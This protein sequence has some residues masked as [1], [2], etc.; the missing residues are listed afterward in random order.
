MYK[1][2]VGTVKG[3][4]VLSSDDR[5]NRR[6]S[7]QVFRGWKLAAVAQSVSKRFL[8]EVSSH[9]D[10]TTVHLSGDLVEWEQVDKGLSSSTATGHTL[11]QIWRF[12]VSPGILYAGALRGALPVD[13]EDRCGVYAGTTSRTVRISAGG[14]DS[15]QTLPHILQRI[16]CIQIFTDP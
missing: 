6:Q 8:A 2:I 11:D 9:V 5:K 15:W 14:G 12:G 16:L 4:F 10:G 13:S 7:G 1:L 3:G